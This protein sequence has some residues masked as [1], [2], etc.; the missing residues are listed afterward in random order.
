MFVV[1]LSLI[2]PFVHGLPDLQ[3]RP[4]S[5]DFE[6]TTDPGIGILDAVPYVLLPF[7]FH[8][9]F[10]VYRFLTSP[11]CEEAL[12]RTLG[13]CPKCGRRVF[14]IRVPS[15]SPAT[16]ESGLVWRPVLLS[17]NWNSP[18][19]RT[20]ASTLFSLSLSDSFATLRHDL[21]I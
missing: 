20:A 2:H 10:F 15:R 3:R 1:T 9:S 19:F 18:F 6:Q 21:R 12:A 7:Y 14:G 11:S 13:S 16:G 8:A 17:S 4:W 5:R